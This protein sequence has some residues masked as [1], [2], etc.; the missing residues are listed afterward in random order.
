MDEFCEFPAAKV[1][2]HK[3]D[4]S[5]GVNRIWVQWWCVF[6]GPLEGRHHQGIFMLRIFDTPKTT[7]NCFVIYEYIRGT[8]KLNEK[9]NRNPGIKKTK[10][11]VGDRTVDGDDVS[12]AFPPAENWRTPKKPTAA[13]GIHGCLLARVDILGHVQWMRAPQSE[14]RPPRKSAEVQ[15]SI[16]DGR[17]R[18]LV[19]SNETYNIL[20]F[21]CS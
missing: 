6:T 9:R 10:S 20:N 14:C 2:A 1:F 15:E 8:P 5:A 3:Q 13:D 19:M 21:P 12:P 17:L 16:G 11:V 4:E 7:V 18:C